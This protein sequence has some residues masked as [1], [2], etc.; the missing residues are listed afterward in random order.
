MLLTFWGLAVFKIPSIPGAPPV[1]GVTAVAGAPG[2][3]TNYGEV[4]GPVLPLFG[5]Y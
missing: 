2:V 3:F 4:G 5:S 1:A